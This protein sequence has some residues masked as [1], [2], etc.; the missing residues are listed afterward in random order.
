MTETTGCV[1]DDGAMWAASAQ[2]AASI[3]F[4]L[5][6]VLGTAA[7]F[8]IRPKGVEIPRRQVGAQVYLPLVIGEAVVLAFVAAYAAHLLPC[9]W[10]DCHVEV[11]DTSVLPAT[12]LVTVWPLTALAILVGRWQGWRSVSLFEPMPAAAPVATTEPTPVSALL[13]GGMSV[14]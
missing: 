9:L 14:A 4:L 3:T 13:F 7:F 6:A 8:A 1:V 11:G 5:L 2:R 12:I 10:S